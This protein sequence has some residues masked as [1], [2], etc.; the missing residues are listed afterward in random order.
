MGS[1]NHEE[2]KRVISILKSINVVKYG[3]FTLKD[4]SIS[5]I[6]IDL[7]ILPNF[8]KEFKEL[9]KITTEYLEKLK[10]DEKIDGIIAPPLAGIPFGVALALNLNKEF[11]LARMKPK[12]HGTKKL[13]EGDISG[14]RILIVDD[15]ITSGGSKIP[16]IN[17]IKDNDGIP[18][19]LFVFVNRI[20]SKEELLKF[21]KEASSKV[22]FLLSLDDLTE[23]EYK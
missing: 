22:E 3:K 23:T 1:L 13:I 6:Y 4:G 8:P 2:V 11:Y 15:V 16:I 19:A 10:I 12:E 20:H 18:V 5:P 17:A 21:E 7:R 14:K 9:M